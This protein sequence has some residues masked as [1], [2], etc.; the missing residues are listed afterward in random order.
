MEIVSAPVANRDHHLC[1]ICRHVCKIIAAVRRFEFYRLVALGERRC[2]ASEGVSILVE[3]LSDMEW[4]V[5]VDSCGRTWAVSSSWFVQENIS[6][7]HSIKITIR[8]ASIAAV[9]LVSSCAPSIL[10]SL[11]DVKFGAL[12]PANGSCIAVLEWII[13]VSWSRHDY[14][15]QGCQAPAATLT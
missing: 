1:H 3:V 10:V 7:A 8:P 6:V 9:T 4:Q 13:C 15:V 5:C 12:V 11:H 2:I 14:R